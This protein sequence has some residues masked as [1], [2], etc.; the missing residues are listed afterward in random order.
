MKVTSFIASLA[1]ACVV[2]GAAIAYDLATHARMSWEAYLR[3]QINQGSAKRAQLGLRN[4]SYT[5]LGTQYY[6]VAGAEERPRESHDFDWN[7]YK[8]PKVINTQPETVQVIPPGWLMRGAVREDDA[9]YG[10]GFGGPISSGNFDWATWPPQ[11]DPYG[12]FNRFCN[13][14]FDPLN[15]R[16]LSGAMRE[17]LCLYDVKRN[18]VQWALGLSETATPPG[19]L[20]T[21][22]KRRNHFAL[23]DALEAMWRALTLTTLMT[24][25]LGWPYL[26]ESATEQEK[27]RTAY[28]ATAFRALGDVLHLVQ[29]MAQPQHTRNE[30]HPLGEAKRY[31]QYIDWRTKGVGTAEIITIDG[32]TI[33]GNTVLP[34]PA[35]QGYPIPRFA[36]YFD[37]WSTGVG[38]A[39]LTGQ[40]LA[41]YS[42]R[43]FLTLGAI[44][45]GREYSHPPSNPELLRPA[46]VLD[47]NYGRF[48]YFVW[49]VVDTL[50]GARDQAHMARKGLWYDKFRVAL[51]RDA[52]PTRATIGQDE[53]VFND[54]ARLLIPRAV[55]YSTGVLDHFFR[56]AMEIS[57]GDLNAYAVT[58]HGTVIEAGLGGGLSRGFDKIRL[59]L[60]NTTP[61]IVLAAGDKVPQ[62][63]TDGRLVAVVKFHRNNCFQDDLGGEPQTAEDIARC[64]SETEEIVTSEFATTIDGGD[65]RSVPF[66]TVDQPDGIELSFQFPTY[67]Q[68]PLAAWDVILQ[69]V[70]RGKLGDEED[71]VVVASKDISEPTFIHFFDMSD[72]YLNDPPGAP[73]TET[74]VSGKRYG[75]DLYIQPKFRMSGSNLGITLSLGQPSAAQ[76]IEQNF[77]GRI[78]RIAGLFEVDKAVEMRRFVGDYG[79]LYDPTESAVFVMPQRTQLFYGDLADEAETIAAQRFKEVP[80]TDIGSV[81]WWIPDDGWGITE[82]NATGALRDYLAGRLRRLNF[83]TPVTILNW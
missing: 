58:D 51:G 13:H 14:F 47:Q 22:A 20:P 27:I 43:G 4:G 12:N 81:M 48:E 70:Y 39:S 6:D 11:D 17:G 61:E 40:G 42:S 72:C 18:A 35:Y 74:G 2:P 36:R 29:D 3:A 38:T 46:Q 21:D 28:W 63:M 23:P 55:A 32:E 78:T 1:L 77:P 19:P 7:D 67:N 26:S 52:V 53:L 10:A 45:D 24:D 54:Y 79:P 33:P 34:P 68:I 59:K 80:V 75:A 69:V 25:R 31:E 65:V 30:I 8:F 9:G 57:I 50:T 66:A 82:S 5:D 56:G 64:R 49:D 73:C 15:N 41:D 62:P 37:Y 44:R 60:K 71:A 76:R 16:P 83:P